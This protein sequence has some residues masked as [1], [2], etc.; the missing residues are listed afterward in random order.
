MFRPHPVGG[1]RSETLIHSHPV[2]ERMQQVGV[3]AAAI[4][5]AGVVSRRS[6]PVGPATVIGR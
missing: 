1:R 4:D 6:D 3:W 2:C 5:R